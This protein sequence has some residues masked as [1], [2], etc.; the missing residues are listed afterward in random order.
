[1]KLHLLFG[2]VSAAGIIGAACSQ[3]QELSVTPLPRAHAHNDY[4]HERPLL[5]ALDQGFCSVEADIFLVD[6]QLLVAHSFLELS[7]ERTLE[8]LYFKPL[9]ERVRENGGRVYPNGPEVTLLIDI[10]NNGAETYR[11]LDELLTK[12]EDVFTATIDGTV[13][14]RAVTAIISGDRAFDVIA[15]DA[16]R[17]A[18]IDG[19][20]SDLDSDRSSDLM[21]L[22]SDNWRNHF[23]WRGT[24][25]FPEEERR[26]LNQI[27]QQAH[28]ENRRVRFWAS[29]DNTAVW[30]VLN[31]AGV[32]LINTD[33]LPGLATF[34]HS[35]SASEAK[36]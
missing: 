34:L 31:A 7:K 9:R 1:M 19:R 2:L 14:A 18:G 25:H 21:P 36:Q 24:G 6:G 4:L 30:N 16:T 26:K 11:A 22:I 29:P 13:R 10:K 5:D 28:Q 23:Q 17:Y 12:Y 20:V 35:T 3:A 33:D 8:E 32:D 15:A 27:V